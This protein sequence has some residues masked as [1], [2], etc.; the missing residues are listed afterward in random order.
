MHRVSGTNCEVDPIVEL[1]WS[2]A[3]IPKWE[4][5]QEMDMFTLSLLIDTIQMWET[6]ELGKLSK[7]LSKADISAIF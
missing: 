3:R 4:T 6:V 7:K 1:I 5:V 2:K